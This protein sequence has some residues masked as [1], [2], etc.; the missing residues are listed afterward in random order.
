MCRGSVS[1]TSLIGLTLIFCGSVAS[2]NQQSSSTEPGA[3]VSVFVK[4][5]ESSVYGAVPL[6]QQI[7]VTLVGSS[8][9]HAYFS[10]P[11]VVDHVPMQEIASGVYVGKYTV[12]DGHDVCG[13][14]IVGQLTAKDG[15]ASPM[16]VAPK[17][18]TIDTARPTIDQPFPADGE[19]IASAR[20]LLYCGFDDGV[21]SGIDLHSVTVDVDRRN[22]TAES[23][24]AP[25]GVSYRP[26]SDL[27][28]GEHTFTVSVAD[29][30]G[31]PARLIAH[32]QVVPP[33]PSGIESLSAVG[34]SRI[35]ANQP[36]A[37]TL[38]GAPGGDAELS[39]PPFV[40]TT[41]LMEVRPGVYQGKFEAALGGSVDGAPVVVRLSTEAATYEVSLDHC[42]SVT[43]GYT[44]S[45]T[46]TE[47]SDSD[48]FQGEI[49]MRGRALPGELVECTVSYA[50]RS[51]GGIM[52]FTGKAMSADVYANK[53]GE[54]HMGPFR[55]QLK[56][57]YEHNRDTDLTLSAVALD[58]GSHRSE[59]VEE[60]VDY[61]Q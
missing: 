15:I 26:E 5:F 23:T 51:E 48:E 46:I 8:A 19:H 43:A 29:N 54:W 57:L 16:L 3:V 60:S 40:G 21:G 18:I 1:L 28:L 52:P 61:S 45:P 2:A 37:I 35:R 38:T 55:L 36:L 12:A 58:A 41:K 27:T 53:K 32:F 6:G 17:P 49:E 44:P 14:Q 56:S 59:P 47:P 24:I 50:S 30:A 10:I 7:L 34:P 11:N 33:S 25:F 9:G 4:S 39:I 13:G 42:I 20:P 31:N 22:V